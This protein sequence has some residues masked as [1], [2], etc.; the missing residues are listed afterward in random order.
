MTRYCGLF[1]RFPGNGSLA[2]CA[3][4]A[5]VSC[6]VLTSV[7]S[8]QV[9]RFEVLG[10][11]TVVRA[12]AAASNPETVRL[13]LGLAKIES[14]LQLGM[15]FLQEGLANPEGSHFSHPRVETW[16]GI[17][18]GVIAA[19]GPDLEGILQKLE[20]GGGKDAVLA[21]YTAAL[22]AVMKAR[23]ALNPTD[24]DIIQ[25]IVAQAKAVVGE[26][27]ASGPTAAQ[28]F[29]D[30]WAMLMVARTQ[31]DLLLRNQDPAV[32]KA[33][34]EMAMALDDVIISMPDPAQSAPVLFDPA[35]ILAAVSKLEGMAGSV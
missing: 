20:G 1:S 26:I 3:A 32:A 11:A 17:K 12:Q 18:E 28:D 19:G 25:S 21:N 24:Q 27:N 6:L 29:Q 33:A 9:F 22:G 30:G 23:S 2:G 14:D 34:A 7:A 31:V 13:L 5:A 10:P 35:P 8:A 15:L 16:P 4:V